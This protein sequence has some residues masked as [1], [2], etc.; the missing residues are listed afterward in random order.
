MKKLEYTEKLVGERRAR[1]ETK[2][3]EMEERQIR[4]IRVKISGKKKNTQRKSVG[5][6]RKDRFKMERQAEARRKTD[7]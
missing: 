6:K 3:G 1:S 5:R 4:R 7:N 2:R